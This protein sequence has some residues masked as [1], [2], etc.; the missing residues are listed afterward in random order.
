MLNLLLD[1]N[2]GY[3]LL[4]GGFVLAVLALFTPGTGVLELGALFALMLAGYSLV[5]L[6][7]N[8]WAAGLA[9]LG[10]V[11]LF[12]ALRRKR[13]R[14]NLLL[15]LAGT[16]MLVLGSIFVFRGPTGGLAVSPLLAVLTSG[17]AGLLLWFVARKYLDASQ[18]TPAHSLE[19]LVGMIG[20]VKT[21]LRPDGSVYVDGE[22]WSAT[23]QNYLPA[24]TR[25]RV[26]ARHGLSLEVEKLVEEDK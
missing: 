14:Q 26:T 23:S 24:G 22:E 4:V 25:V 17:G 12:L 18:E 3:L 5:N 6:P 13:G 11:P 19:N 2:V 7:V 21:D 20:T 15:I 10:L 1:P 8:T 16:A 9:L